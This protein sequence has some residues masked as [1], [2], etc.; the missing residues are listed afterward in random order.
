MNIEGKSATATDDSGLMPYLA[1]FIEECTEKERGGMVRAIEL[2]KLYN[3]W[4]TDKKLPNFTLTMFG[5]LMRKTGIP[6]RVARHNH[7]M[8]IRIRHDV[9][10][11]LMR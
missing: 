5:I 6:K 11:R 1:E 8:G 2:Y 7:Y 9:R 10:E 4:A 3:M